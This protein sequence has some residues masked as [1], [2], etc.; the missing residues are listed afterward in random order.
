MKVDLRESVFCVEWIKNGNKIDSTKISQPLL[1]KNLYFVMVSNT[2][3]NQIEITIS[4]G[5]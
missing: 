5:F 2:I 1:G 3:D 4:N